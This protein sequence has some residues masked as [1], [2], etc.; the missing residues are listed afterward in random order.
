MHI[1]VVTKAT[2][3]TGAKITV[4][5]GVPT[6]KE[7]MVIN[8]WDEYSVT[9]AVVL[10]EE[11][12]AKVTI[13][14]VGP[15][16]HDDALKQGLAIGCDEAIRVWDEAL[17]GHDSLQYARALAAAI[18]KLG[19]V[20]LVIF[21]KEF[22]DSGSNQHIYQTAR[23]LGFQVLGSVSKLISLDFGAGT[24]KVERSVEQGKQTVSSKLPAVLGVLKDITEPRYPSFIGIRK[25][26]KA[27]IPV[28]GLSDLGIEAST[29][30]ATI[31]SY[32]E[33]PKREGEVEFIEGESPREIAEKLAEK[34]LEEKVL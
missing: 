32:S 27:Q 22:A 28:W 3:D 6:W 9:E 4:E 21:G 16:E 8:P 13:M 25:A 5:N 33:P 31:L 11:H 20:T 30:K 1:V 18:K 17:V 24:I 12:K 23:L 14:A 26:A 29:P 10:K 7:A 15:A 19:D 2:P 34:L